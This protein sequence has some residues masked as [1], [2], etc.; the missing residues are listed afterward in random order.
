MQLTAGV[1]FRPEHFEEAVASPADG[2]WFE[3]HAENYMVEGGPRLAMLEALRT[4][5]PLSLHGVG[6]S[7]AGADE[8]NP[9]HLSK[10]RSLIDRFDPALVSEHLAWSMSGGTYFPDLLPFPRSHAMLAVVCRNIQITQQ[11]LGRAISVENPALYLNVGGHDW[12]ET[13][14]LRELVSRTGCGL[15]VDANNIHVSATNLGFAALDYVA[16]LPAAAVTEY[17]L[18][19][20]SADPQLGSSL[21]IDSHDQ[22]VAPIV[23][24]LFERLV[25][26][27]GPKPALIER[28]GNVPPFG[29]LM[30]ERGRAAELLASVLEP[31][32]A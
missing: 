14:F 2:L 30:V 24:A 23:W 15:L 9:D 12:S 4:A 29:E 13:D 32:N 3:V 17:H 25:Y 20:Y 28:D 10:L 5:R 21:L 18:A 22:P 27:I 26:Q 19:G 11:A 16:A 1:G 31:Q 6:L 8:P 7:L